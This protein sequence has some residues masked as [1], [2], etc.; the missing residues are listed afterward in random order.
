M[1]FMKR[2]NIF[3]ESFLVTFSS[4]DEKLSQRAQ[5]SFKILLHSLSPPIFPRLYSL[6]DSQ[7]LKNML[8]DFNGACRVELHSDMKQ[9]DNTVRL[10]HL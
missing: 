5:A 2:K 7:G 8:E 1:V 10:A 9:K 6:S 3:Q 4:H